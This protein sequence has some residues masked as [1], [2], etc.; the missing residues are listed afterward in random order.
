MIITHI[1]YTVRAE[2][3]AENQEYIGAK[4]ATLAW[5]AK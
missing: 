2:Y 5:S 4:C 1:Q 3:V